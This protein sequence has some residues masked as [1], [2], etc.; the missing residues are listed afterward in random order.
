[1]YAAS[2]IQNA[3][4]THSGSGSPTTPAYAASSDHVSGAG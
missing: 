2:K 3:S 4:T 1:M